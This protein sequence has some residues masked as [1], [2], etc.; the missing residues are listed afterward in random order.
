MTGRRPGWR[1][2]VHDRHIRIPFKRKGRSCLLR[3]TVASIVDNDGRIQMGHEITNF[4]FKTAVGHVRRE[5]QVARRV[6][7][8]FANVENR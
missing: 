4:S 7:A 2:A 8:C 3:H 1:T 5:K 6:L